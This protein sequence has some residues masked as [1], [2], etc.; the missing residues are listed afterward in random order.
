M[1]NKT[2]TNQ[3]KQKIARKKQKEPIDRV[4]LAYKKMVENGGKSMYQIMLECGYSEAYAKN[5]KKLKSTKKWKELTE[6]HLSDLELIKIHKS[7]LQSRKIDN[8]VFPLGLE[9]YEIIELLSE[10]GCVVRR[11]QETD[12]QKHVWF[13]S[14]DNRS[15]L[16]ALDKAYKIK[17][18]YAPQE[19]KFKREFE[20]LSDEELAETLQTIKDELT[21]KKK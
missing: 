17:N 1:K 14:P 15:R 13:W 11:F 10:V 8:A 4:V 5:S 7:I 3:F 21:K 20:D 12:F 19:V 6:E 16:D 9:D 2:K 18:K